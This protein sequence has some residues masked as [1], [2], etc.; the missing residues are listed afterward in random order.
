M[1]LY[2]VECKVIGTRGEVND[3]KHP[4][5]SINHRLLRRQ[6]AE[7]LG[8][9]LSCL[10]RT[11]FVPPRVRAR[12]ILSLHSVHQT[13]GHPTTSSCDAP[14]LL[15]RPNQGARTGSQLAAKA[16]A[17]S[18]SPLISRDALVGF[19]LARSLARTFRPLAHLLQCHTRG[20]LMKLP[21]GVT[22]GRYTRHCHV[23]TDA[24][25]R[26]AAAMHVWS[27]R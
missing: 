24:L 12:R 18:R 20:P 27:Q 15:L 4:P 16:R 26:C 17:R 1:S 7:E 13:L 5:V 3:S 25:T 23:R 6:S 9:E 19:S 22:P 8:T 21:H 14:V 2:L 10:L 11:P